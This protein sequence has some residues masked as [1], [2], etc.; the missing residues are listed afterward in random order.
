MN[1]TIM[2]ATAIV[3]GQVALARLLSDITGRPIK[4]QHVWNWIHRG[5][6]IPAELAIPIERATDGEITRHEVR[7]DIYPLDAA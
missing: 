2:R 5:D 3:G 7:P 4:Q 6:T 1:T